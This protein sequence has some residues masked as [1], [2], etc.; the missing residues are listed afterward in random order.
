MAHRPRTRPF[1]A[2]LAA[3]SLLAGACTGAE[4]ETSEAAE[5]STSV[6][7]T[8]PSTS[9]PSTT[10]STGSSATSGDQ[11]AV[12]YQDSL[13]PQVTSATAI[14]VVTVGEG[15]EAVTLLA[16][17]FEPADD[18]AA[19]RA[20]MVL[21]F[22]G[23]F[24]GG[25]RD[26]VGMQ[27]LA[28]FLARHGFVVATVDYRVLGRAPVDAAELSAAARQ[29]VLDGGA[30]VEAFRASVGDGNPWRID[31]DRIF[32]GGISA[33]GVIAASL[34]T[35][36]GATPTSDA[37][38]DAFSGVAGAFVISGAVTDLSVVD[39][40][41]APMFIAHEELDPV[42]PCEIGAEGSSNTG[43]TIAGGCALLERADEVGL[44]AEGFIAE[45]QAGHVEFTPAQYE[46]FLDA[47]TDFF[48]PLA[49]GI[50]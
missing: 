14:E 4:A 44:S 5:P 21:F 25:E 24:I 45:G 37:D 34:A 39:A 30:S 1:V 38:L 33:G 31:P 47:A 50:G 11:E 12:R 29:A 23:G 27:A 16:D 19:A 43:A 48:A 20:L 2:L 18:D 26:S 8:V 10:T 46:E 22:G 32:V 36:L 28:S 35:G 15:D 6:G 49:S 3:G 9:A 42:V 13:F 7:F 41:D 40:D 17:V